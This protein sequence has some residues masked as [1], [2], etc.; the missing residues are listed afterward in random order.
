VIGYQNVAATADAA[1][2]G[3][4]DAARAHNYGYIRHFSSPGAA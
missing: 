1:S 3:L 2:D 4:T